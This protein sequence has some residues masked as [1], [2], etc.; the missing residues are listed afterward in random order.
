[1]AANKLNKNQIGVFYSDLS[2]ICLLFDFN[3]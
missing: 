3:Y 2:L 1:M